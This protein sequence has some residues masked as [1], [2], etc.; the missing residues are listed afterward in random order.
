M[1]AMHHDANAD[2]LNL[3]LA[4]L[5]ARRSEALLAIKDCEDYLRACAA[6]TSDEEKFHTA[7]DIDDH[8]KVLARLEREIGELRDRRRWE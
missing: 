1:S 8:R 6:F 5:L 7:R 2:P 3:Q 4:A